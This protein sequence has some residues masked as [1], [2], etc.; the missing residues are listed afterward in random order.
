[1]TEA[2]SRT[3]LSWSQFLLAFLGSGFGAGLFD[4]LYTGSTGDLLLD[5]L[6]AAAYG[7]GFLI[8][9]LLGWLILR[10]KRNPTPRRSLA[11]AAAV[12]AILV[13][14]VSFGK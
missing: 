8:V 1:M 9:L 6:G 7:G 3:D 2:K 12:C 13:I 11:I 10:S 14:A 4:R 5:L